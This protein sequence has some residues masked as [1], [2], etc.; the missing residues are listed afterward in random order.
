MHAHRAKAGPKS[1]TTGRRSVESRASRTPPS[2]P[3]RSEIDDDKGI[4]WLEIVAVNQPGVLARIAVEIASRG[5]N[6]ES[7]VTKERSDISGRMVIH[8]EC[9]CDERTGQIV[10]NAIGKF[11]DVI[12]VRASG[13]PLP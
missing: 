9:S 5:V 4:Y 1:A 3:G 2:I 10:S 6:I 13:P 8:V 11:I 12:R 7:E